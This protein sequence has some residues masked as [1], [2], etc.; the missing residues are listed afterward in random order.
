MNVAGRTALVTG[1]A[2]RIGRA[3]CEAL[4][5][6]GCNVVVHYHKSQNEAAELVSVLRTRGVESF[7]VAGD[8]TLEQT[9]QRVIEE[10]RSETGAL[11]ILVN[12]ASVF[13][14]D[15]LLEASE[16][17]VLQEIKTNLL[18]PLA[19]MRAFAAQTG[20]G[21]IVSLLDRRIAGHEAGC[22][23][24]LVSKKA[25]AEL[26]LSAA[27]ELAP[28]ITV[29]AVAPGAV[30]PPPGKG[31]DYMRDHAGRVPLG[32]KVTPQDV[33]R[34]VVFLLENDA[35]TGQVIFVDGGQ[36]LLGGDV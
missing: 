12:N 33:A 26:T 24:Y 18:A 3:I 15:S 20:R 36:H 2:V 27:L 7:A 31:D 34:A 21:R 16:D 35:I 25:L 29:N 10:A 17:K 23:P 4:A 14:K 8:L 6:R 11:D 19:L 1:G 9:C 30:L 13:R 32:I 5:D 22:I 28:A